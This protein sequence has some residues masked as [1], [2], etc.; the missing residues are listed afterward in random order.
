MADQSADVSLVYRCPCQNRICRRALR[1]WQRFWMRAAAVPGLYRLGCACAAVGAP[2]HL[3][4]TALARL[5]QVGYMAR[6]ACVHHGRFQRGANVFVDDRVLICQRR[7]GEAIR[8]GDRVSVYR[9]CILETGQGGTITVG[10]DSSIHP[11]CQLNAYLAPI[12]I[13]SGVMIAS[14]CALYSY[15]HGLVRARPI[16]E[17]PLT[18]KGPIVIGDEAWLGVGVVVVSGVRI[19]NGAAIGAGSVV[20]H[21]IP[22]AAIAHGVPARLVKTRG[23]M[24]S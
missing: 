1:L 22:D 12:E 3:E 23:E 13:G 6:S 18:T 9:D 24:P 19:G 5:S 14:N 20:T 17:Q 21:D 11:R 4:R 2:P 10:T 8:L 15:D 7:G 16:R